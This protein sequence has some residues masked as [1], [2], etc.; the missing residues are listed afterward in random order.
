MQIVD[1]QLLDA[2]DANDHV[3]GVIR[4]GDVFAQRANFRVVHAFV[5][6]ALGELLLQQ[7]APRRRHPL[8]W[9]SSVA[10]FV[11]SGEST[12]RRSPLRSPRSSVAPI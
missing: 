6:N 7:I 5:F 12:I 8:M 1:Q 3:I 10:G 2:V 4:R 9:G 11:A